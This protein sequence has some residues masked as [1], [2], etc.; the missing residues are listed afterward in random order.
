[1]AT[2]RPEPFT[3]S[4]PQS[5]RRMC[6]GLERERDRQSSDWEQSG[7]M[8]GVNAQRGT[9]YPSSAADGVITTYRFSQVIGEI[10]GLE[11]ETS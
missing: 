3:T 4:K 10:Y 1:M 11:S 9:W 8:G 7:Q 5:T 6:G 2:V